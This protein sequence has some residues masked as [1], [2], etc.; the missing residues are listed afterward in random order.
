MKNDP[1]AD[2]R[3]PSEI[4]GRQ[5]T[6]GSYDPMTCVVHLHPEFQNARSELGTGVYKAGTTSPEA[7]DAQSTYLHETIHWWQHVGSTAGLALSLCYPAQAHLNHRY[8]KQLLSEIAPVKSLRQ[9]HLDYAGSYAGTSV[10]RAL[11]ITLNNWHDIE[12][13]RYIMLEPEK[14]D[15]FIQSRY[16]ESV[17]HS[18]KVTW[19]ALLWLLSGVADPDLACVQDPRRWESAFAELTARKVPNFAY[20]EPIRLPEFGAL[21]LFEGQARLNQIQFLS[22]VHGLT[23]GWTDLELRGMLDG[24]YGTAFKGMLRGL[25]EPWPDSPQSPFVGLFLLLCDIAIN[26]TEGFPLPLTFPEAFVLDTDPG[27]RFIRLCQLVRDKFPSMKTAV[28]KYSRA[29]YVELSEELCQA[30]MWPSPLVAASKVSTWPQVS[31]G[32]GQ[33]MAQHSRSRFSKENLP[34][35][36]FAARFVQMQIDKLSAPQFFTWPGVWSSLGAEQDGSVDENLRLL[37]RHV[38]MFV[39]NE[40]G[41]VRPILF[42]GIEE[43]ALYDTAN[44]FFSWNALYGLIRQWQ[45]ED[46]PFTFDFDYFGQQ[47]QSAEIETGASALFETTFNVPPHAFNVL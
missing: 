18:Y 31:D 11:N 17:G 38:P 46:G 30:A 26:P 40:S 13:L 6:R 43:S 33:L 16:F 9:Y 2:W 4:Y 19:S 27:I 42:D 32:F 37:N 39:R 29:E 45:I 41:E 10:E 25:G 22:R 8:L 3:L 12:H 34:V 7:V 36:V 15:R 5:G 14:A 24:I 21:A 1:S 23:N 35:R 20:G 28:Q 47:H 44:K